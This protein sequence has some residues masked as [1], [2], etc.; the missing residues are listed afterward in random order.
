[1]KQEAADAGRW[2]SEL[3]PTRSFPVIQIL[4]AE[5]ILA[6]KAADVPGWG[7]ETFKKA[8]RQKLEVVVQE[9]LDLTDGVSAIEN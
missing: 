6:G 8:T 3:H 2:T 5:D 7:L 1:M 9:S 4:T